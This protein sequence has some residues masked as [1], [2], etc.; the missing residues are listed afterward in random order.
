MLL[1]PFI[2]PGTGSSV[3]YNHYS[4]LRSVEDLFGLPYLGYAAANAQT[5]F[6]GDVFTQRM[7]EFPAKR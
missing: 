5:A 4:L 1:S 2:K 3:A 7:P 6:G